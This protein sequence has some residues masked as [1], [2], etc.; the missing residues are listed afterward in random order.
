M[1]YVEQQI[2]FEEFKGKKELSQELVSLQQV[3]QGKLDMLLLEINSLQERTD[4][5]GLD[6]LLYKKRLYQEW[7]EVFKEVEAQKAT[8]LTNRI[9][10][11]LQQYVTDYGKEEGY[12]YILGIGENSNLMYGK[13]E[14]EITKQVVDYANRKYEGK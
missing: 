2:L 8:D 9:W 4:K 7:S 12:D 6:S 5:I 3:Q 14:R 11:Q 13:P 10:V 1:G